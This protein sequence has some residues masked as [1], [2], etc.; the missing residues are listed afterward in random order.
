MSQPEDL[1]EEP[2]GAVR[3]SSFTVLSLHPDGGASAA[4]FCSYEAAF[5]CWNR[6]CEDPAGVISCEMKVGNK[7]IMKFDREEFSCTE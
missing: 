5:A 2:G 4:G 7:L 3:R 1:S 6:L